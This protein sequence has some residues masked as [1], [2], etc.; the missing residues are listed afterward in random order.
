MASKEQVKQ[1]L[2]YWFQLGKRILIH[3]A[4]P[5]A[6][7]HNIVQG[8][9]YSD[10]FEALWEEVQSHHAHDAYLEGTTQT[11]ANLLSSAWIITSCARCD[12]PVPMLDLGLRADMSCPC[13]DLPNWPDTDLPAPRSPVPSTQRLQG[14]SDRLGK[15]EANGTR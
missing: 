14:I 13:T 2:A 9:R 10:D 8:D 12:M 1:Y 6:S 5:L 7:P 11:I 3:N 4:Q 15:K